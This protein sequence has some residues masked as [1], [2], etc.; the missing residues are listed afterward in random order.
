LHK[1]SATASQGGEG[2]E[3]KPLHLDRAGDHQSGVA[4][5]SKT[6]GDEEFL[7]PRMVEKIDDQF[8]TWRGRRQQPVQEFRI[9][10]R[11]PGAI[12]R[13]G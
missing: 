2:E 4:T 6:G 9:V 3:A 1:K 8:L 11:L 13:P 12:P 5:G 10:P 7:S